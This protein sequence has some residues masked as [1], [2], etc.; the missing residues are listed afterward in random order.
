LRLLAPQAAEREVEL[1]LRVDPALPDDLYSDP[2]RL[3]QIFLNLVGNGIRFT[4][5]GTVT[6]TAEPLPGE[7]PAIRCEVSDTGVGI[8]PE[9]QE[10]LFQ[11]FAQGQSSASH[12]F[13]GTG[14]GLVICRNIVELMGGEIGFHSTHG[15]GSTF[16]F[17]VPLV[18]AR[19]GTLPSVIPAMPAM[20][21]GDAEAQR[22]ARH[23]RRIL[24]VDD[25][26]ANRSVALALLRRLG[27]TAEAVEGGEEALAFLAEKPCAAV[28]LDLEMVG[29][30]GFETCRRLRRQEEAGGGTRTPRTP[31]IALSAHTSEEERAQC[32][33]AG[34]DAFL[35]KPFRTD[36]L[37]AVLD[38]WTRV[39]TGGEPEPAA[40]SL[41]ERL[42]ALKSLGSKTGEPLLAEVVVET[43]LRQ[44]EV[45]LA[46]LQRALPQGDGATVAAAAHGL[47]GSAAILGAADLARC[48]GELARLA[49]Q[50]ELAELAE[51]TAWAPRLAEVEEEFRMVVQRLAP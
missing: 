15:A 4:R 5:K 45:D 16:W 18:P 51:M 31:V 32:F 23:G 50:G 26:A 22:L 49:R 14:L 25:R 8:R 41:E 6:V 30:D 37:A 3:R 33:A 1:R 47:A 29:L 39:E 34:M 10:R 2:V 11:P 12:A 44:G 17:R 20:P 43:F 36:E 46:A 42:A 38:L 48:A 40:E 7:T 13:G 27:Y 19:G 35:P 24:V 21:V 9:V 28:L